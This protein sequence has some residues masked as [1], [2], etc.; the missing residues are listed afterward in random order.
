MQFS[1]FFN[2]FSFLPQE[3]AR[4]YCVS[5]TVIGD[6]PLIIT[7]MLSGLHTQNSLGGPAYRQSVLLPFQPK[8]ER[9]FFKF[10]RTSSFSKIQFFHL[11]PSSIPLTF[12]K[13]SMH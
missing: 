13:C 12:K 8:H 9:T 11:L 10:L 6:V 7:L 4:P 5:F 2:L 3:N 1:N